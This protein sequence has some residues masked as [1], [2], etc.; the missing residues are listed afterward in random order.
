[1]VLPGEA[2]EVREL[3]GARA[4]VEVPILQEELSRNGLKANALRVEL[5]ARRGVPT[6]VWVQWE[7]RP[8]LHFSGPNDRHYVVER[9]RG[10]VIFGDGQNGR[11]P[12]IGPNNIVA[13]YQTGGGTAGN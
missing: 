4:A 6:E 10:R 2:I 13:R 1:P 9:A 8:H 5:D 7:S 11:I 3:D 12:P